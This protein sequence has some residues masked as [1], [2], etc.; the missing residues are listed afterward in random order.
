MKGPR[1]ALSE[2]TRG[3]DGPSFD[4]GNKI[5]PFK[6]INHRLIRSNVHLHSAHSLGGQF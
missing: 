6:R 3:I 4:K 5:S 1:V 2:E